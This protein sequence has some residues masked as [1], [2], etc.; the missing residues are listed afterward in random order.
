M[1]AGVWK[2]LKPTGAFWLAIGDEYAAELKVLAQRELEFTCEAGSSGTTTFGVNCTRAFSR[3]HTISSISSKTRKRSR[4]MRRSGGARSV[5]PAIG[6]RRH[7]GQSEGPAPR[8]LVDTSSAG[9]SPRLSAGR[10]HLVLL[11]RRRHVKEREGFHGCQMPEQLLGRIIR[12]CSNPG[13]IVLDP[14]G[15]SGTT[16][17]VAKKL[18]RQWIGFELS[19]DYV[20]RIKSRLRETRVGEPLDGAARS[21]NK[22]P[23]TPHTPKT[24]RHQNPAEN[25]REIDAPRRPRG[26]Q[27]SGTFGGF[28]YP[29]AFSI[30]Q[31]TDRGHHP[32]SGIDSDR[33]IFCTSRLGISTW[34]GTAST[35]PVRGFIHNQCEPPSR[36]K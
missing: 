36:F 15:G 24:R 22:R 32:I 10:R 5:G 28:P 3:S 12:C 31:Q 35:C 8:Q 7:Q 13:E 26:V 21:A 9:H 30:V 18:D 34:R 14:F 29:R 1:E 6:L 19:T 11:A 20:V 2:A 25:R 16:F 17:T 27:T 23:A 4:S 33:H